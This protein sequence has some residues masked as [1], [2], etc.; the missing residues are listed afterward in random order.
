MGQKVEEVVAKAASKLAVKC[1]GT[2]TERPNTL[3]IDPKYAEPEHDDAKRFNAQ[4]SHST[5]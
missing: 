3:Y 4:S 1:S 5:H 2:G